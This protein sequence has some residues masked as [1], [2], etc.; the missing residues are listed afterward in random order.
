MD[1]TGDKKASVCMHVWAC[2]SHTYPSETC[3]IHYSIIIF[4]I[5]FFFIQYASPR[6]APIL[7]SVVR[8]G[9]RDTSTALGASGDSVLQFVVAYIRLVVWLEQ[10][11]SHGYASL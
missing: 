6:M 11:Q 5:I 8:V 3:D 7:E 4:T 9:R 2:K 1:E 10:C